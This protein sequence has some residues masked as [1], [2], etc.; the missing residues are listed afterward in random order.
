[1]KLEPFSLAYLDAA[2]QFACSNNPE[3]ASSSEEEME[4]LQKT[5]EEQLEKGFGWVL[6][7]KGEFQGFLLASPMEEG[8]PFW[9]SPLGA[10]GFGKQSD[11]VF[12]TLLTMTLQSLE[13]RQA[14]SF[15]LTQYATDRRIDEKLRKFG[16]LPE[17]TYAIR[18]TEETIDQPS[19]FS[20]L[21][22]PP[23]GYE[24]LRPLRDAFTH[25][26]ESPPIQQK[27]TQRE[28]DQWFQKDGKRVFVLN[29]EK[30]H[31]GFF[32]VQ[33]EG[34]TYLAKR[35]AIWNSAGFYLSPTLRGKGLATL[36]LKT[37]ENRLKE[38]GVNQLGTSYANAN[39]SG[40]RFWEKSFRPY[41]IRYQKELR[42]QP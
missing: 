13:E 5:I 8:S 21:E 24:E 34:E 18:D 11:F 16:F 31:V 42:K 27:L 15:C 20:I 28:K 37:V 3:E 14:E 4:L 22:L 17:K 32:A 38:K 25:F 39:L 1:M 23:E 35:K 6:M 26:L 40:K 10:N 36:L 12:D 30:Q 33:K 19:P 29:E 2:L 41:A 7:D 9:V